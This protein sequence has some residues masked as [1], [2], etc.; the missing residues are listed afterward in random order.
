MRIYRGSTQ[1][2]KHIILD[3]FKLLFV[4]FIIGLSLNTNPV[5]ASILY[6]NFSEEV[7]SSYVTTDIDC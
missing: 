4:F 7:K 5:N 6:D 1:M 2:K 3:F